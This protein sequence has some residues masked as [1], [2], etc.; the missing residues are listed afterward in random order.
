MRS[1]MHRLIDLFIEK[2]KWVHGITIIITVIGLISLFSM[3]RDLHPAFKFNY[4]TVN[5]SYP[6]VSANEIERLV[7]YPLEE[8]LRDISDLEEMTSSSQTGQVT[9]TLKFPQ[10]VKNISDKIEE[11]RALV[12]S[13]LR[14]LPSGIRNFA[15]TQSSD[16]KIFLADLGIT[17]IDEQNEVH[18]NFIQSLILKFESVKG[19]AETYSSLK[20]FHIFI[21]FNR[22]RLNQMRVSVAE[23]RNAIRSE[24]DLNSI[25]YN[26]ISGKNW[27]LEFASSAVDL[28]RVKNIQIRNNGSGNKLTIG[29]VAE[30]RFEQLKSENYQFLL[31]GVRTTKITVFKNEKEDSIKTFSHLEK[32]IVEVEKPSGVHI[33][34]LYDGPYFIQ[35]QINVLWQ[36]GFVGLILVLLVLS[37]AMGWRTSLMTAIGLPISYFGT[38]FILKLLGVSIDLISL[39]AMILVVGNLVDDAV[40]FAEKYNQLL[41]EGLEPKD[42]ASRAAKELIVPVSGTILTII[43]AF[44]PIVLLDSELSVVFFAIPVVITVSLLLSWFETFFILPNHLQHYVKK[45]TAEKASNFFFWLSSHYKIILRHTIKFR[46]WYG[47]ASIGLLVISIMTAAKMPQNFNLSINPPQVEL[48]ITFKEEYDFNKIVELLQPLHSQILRLPKNELDFLQTSL[49]RLYKQGKLYRG[50]KYATLRLVLDKKEIDT[51]TLR[52]TVKNQVDKILENYKPVEIEE[53]VVLANERGSSERRTGLSTIQ[54]MGK[55]EEKFSL[56]RS[57]ILNILKEKKSDIK[58]SNPDNDEPDTYRFQLNR[59]KLGDLGLNKDQLALQI[60]SLTG[61]FEILETRSRGRWMNI[62]LESEKYEPPSIK[63]LNQLRIQPFADGQTVQLSQLGNWVSA[64]FSEKITHKNG[65]RSLKLDFNYDDK[66]TNEQVVKKEL[67]Q[68]LAPVSKKFP[69]LDIHVVDANEQDKAGREWALKVVLFAGICIYL[70]LAFTLG[71]FTQPFIVGLPIPFA[72]MGVIWALK[73]HDMPLGLMVMLGLIGTMGVAVNDSI[74]MVHQVNLIWKKYGT[75]SAE[76]LIDAAASRL[77]AI[78]LTASCTL[79]GVFPTA[80]GLGGESG[81]TQPL[82]FS[83]GWGLTASLLLT[84]FIIPSMMMVLK[85]IKQLLE[86]LIK[87]FNNK[88]KTLGAASPETKSKEPQIDLQY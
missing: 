46:Y 16:S 60:K 86:W 42:A 34:V 19:V 26:S 11:A 82:A 74:V 58:F 79:I 10:S 23:I 30:V 59:E 39:V 72:V 56:A 28:E 47:L 27:L 18:H 48:A 21:K 87:L 36:N 7:T 35:Q 41:T 78:V 45:P 14:L 50:P 29:Q 37:L 67:G 64:G 57:E 71:S 22:E 17:G 68:L 76:L 51:T 9:I 73:L 63:N 54:I 77:R 38:F 44:L 2:T 61:P 55:D 6:D 40:I 24:L 43:F 53:I 33:R 70:I 8:K 80:Y 3:K 49:G 81:F 62:Y 13:E 4:V 83:M 15:V 1:V 84:L 66:K 31:N 12:Q 32:A 25:G 88:V 65:I 69:S 75:E 52:Q 5:L 20:P 85:D